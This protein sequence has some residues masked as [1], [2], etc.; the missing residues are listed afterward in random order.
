MKSMIRKSANL[1]TK[2]N[3]IE[4]NDNILIG[5]SGG[6]D[7]IIMTHILKTLQNNAPFDFKLTLFHFNPINNEIEHIISTFEIPFV[8]QNVDI[9]K[10]I[11]IQKNICPLCSRIRRGIITKY[12]IDNNF[13]KVAL[14]HHL[15]DVIETYYLNQ[16]FNAKQFTLKPI[17][18]AENGIKIIRPL[19]S[20]TENEIKEY[21]E[22]NNINI[23]RESC[24]FGNLQNKQRQIIKNML[25]NFTKEM[26]Y[27]IY[28]SIENLF[29]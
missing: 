1:I 4:E 21:V 23:F 10:F 17:Y 16:F 18:T 25:L 5:F 14:G 11:K 22:N 28:H 20:I 9:T 8:V 13:N 24:P 27:N 3:I 19:H 2:Y 29:L 12:A 26:K 6:K 7:S 15:D